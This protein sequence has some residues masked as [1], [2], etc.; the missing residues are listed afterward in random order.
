GKRGRW[1]R[2]YLRRPQPPFNLVLAPKDQ[3]DPRPDET[4]PGVRE[5]C[6]AG[7]AIEPTGHRLAL[8]ALN[9]EPSPV[10]GDQIRRLREV[11]G[12]GRVGDRLVHGA[13]RVVTGS[14]SA[15][16]LRQKRALA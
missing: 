7:Q 10:P 2:A 3:G 12:R 16:K 9:D 15:M 14:G 11:A 8:T 13:L 1:R 5:H 6:L 4:E